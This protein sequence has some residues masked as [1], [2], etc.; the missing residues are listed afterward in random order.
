MPVITSIK[1][2]KKKDR[3]N[4]YLDNKYGFGIDL[5]NFVVLGLRLNQELTDEEIEKIIRKAEFQ[6]T[7]DKLT[8]FA[9]VRPRSKKEFKDYLYRKKIPEVIWEDLLSK[10][11][12]FHLLNDAEFAKWW[13]DTRNSFR[14]KPR[15]IITQE[16]K[17]KGIDKNII[18]DVLDE[19]KINEYQIARNLLVKRESRWKTMD[20]RSRRQ[21]MLQYLVGK[22]FNFEVAQKA[23]KD[24]NSTH[25]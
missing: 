22:G 17:M 15:R 18:D 20:E 21:K 12:D 19:T 24:Y 25:D 5:D 23:V 6:K 7:F 13:V 16:L 10:L 4:I 9:M 3:V 1:Q 8:R 14:P 11:S 2:Q